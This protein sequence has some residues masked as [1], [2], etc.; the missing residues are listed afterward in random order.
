MMLAILINTHM[1]QQ[2]QVIRSEL[3]KEMCPTG[4]GRR[5][6]GLMARSDDASRGDF[7]ADEVDRLAVDGSGGRCTAEKVAGSEAEAAKE[8]LIGTDMMD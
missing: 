6:R 1:V 4:F 5:C 2:T 7:L 3:A 8:G